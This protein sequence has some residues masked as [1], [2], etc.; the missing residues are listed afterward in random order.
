MQS[1][2]A[3]RAEQ[4]QRLLMA[5]HSSQAQARTPLT[6]R[7]IKQNHSSQI[8]DLIGLEARICIYNKLTD[9]VDAVVQNQAFRT[10]VVNSS[11]V[12]LFNMRTNTTVSDL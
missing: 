3:A 1:R 4:H 12:V 11:S 9:I 2:N 10:K 6:Q 8:S 5:E 7:L